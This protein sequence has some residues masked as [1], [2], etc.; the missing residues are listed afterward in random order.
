MLRTTESTQQVILH[1]TDTFLGP[2][3]TMAML[4][5]QTPNLVFPAQ[6]RDSAELLVSTVG[7]LS[8][9]NSGCASALPTA[10]LILRYLA[11]ETKFTYIAR[12]PSLKY[13]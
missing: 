11:T 8:P 10:V 3:H 7:L 5:N 12:P 4:Y 6:Q 2:F 13:L 9:L 1:N